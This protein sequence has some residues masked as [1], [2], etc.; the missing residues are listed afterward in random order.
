LQ[1]I[2]RHAEGV[3]C[4]AL[5]G[6]DAL[7]TLS[8]VSLEW[9]RLQYR[10]SAEETRDDVRALSHRSCDRGRDEDLRQPGRCSYAP[11]SGVQMSVFVEGTRTAKSIT[12]TRRQNQIIRHFVQGLTVA[13]VAKA[14][15]LEEKTVRNHLSKLYSMFEVPGLP[16][17]IAA[18]LRDDRLRGCFTGSAAAVGNANSG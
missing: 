9:Q 7:S 14:L 2:E 15:A 11:T 8:E 10:F 5:E 16:Q 17:L 6:T 13:E 1:V 3:V 18:I 4:G 12:V